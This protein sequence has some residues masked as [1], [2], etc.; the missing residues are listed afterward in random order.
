MLNHMEPCICIIKMT[1]LTQ[2]WN[3]RCHGDKRFWVWH[4][5]Y[6]SWE[7]RWCLRNW[8]LCFA[9]LL[10]SFTSYSLL[11]IENLLLPLNLFDGLLELFFLF[12]DLSLAINCHLPTFFLCPLIPLLFLNPFKFLTQPLFLPIS[13]ISHGLA[14]P[15]HLEL[16]QFFKFFDLLPLAEVL[17]VS[18]LFGLPLSL[19]SCSLFFLRQKN[20]CCFFLLLSHLLDSV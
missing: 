12:T 16:P 19:F 14:L 2:S 3:V 8:G 4:F 7:H 13:G 6:V 5:G 10:C 17:M 20:P 1:S 11:L 9:V 18:I 15:F